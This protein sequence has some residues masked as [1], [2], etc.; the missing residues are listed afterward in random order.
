MRRQPAVHQTD[1]G[2]ERREA[3]RRL[4]LLGAGLAVTACTPLKIVLH[5]YPEDFDKDP[6]RVDRV[7]RAFVTAVLPGAAEDDPDLIRAYHDT[8]Y[9][10][11]K[12]RNFLAAD[13][14]RRAWDG[15]GTDAFHQLPLEQRTEI[16]RCA[17]AS[18]GTTA[19]LYHGAIFLAQIAFYGGIYDDA[20]GCPLIGFEGRYRFRGIEATTHPAP[21]RFLARAITHDGSP[22]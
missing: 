15:F 21:E 18:G 11:G 5:L 12:Y 14:S 10:L 9:P 7:L 16:I 13:L 22:A 19:R 4:A 2:I 1:R 3:V 8:A 20:K 17:V 6:K